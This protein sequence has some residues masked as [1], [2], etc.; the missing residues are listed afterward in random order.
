[1][2]PFFWYHG[3]IFTARGVPGLYADVSRADTGERTRQVGP[4]VAIDGPEDRHT[5]VLF[6]LFGHHHDRTESDTYVFPTFFHQRKADGYAV[7][8]LLPLFWRSRWKDRTTTVVGPFYDRE[9][10]T[11]HDTGLVPLYFWAKN[12]DRTRLIVPPLL[13][14]HHHDFRAGTSTTVVGPFFHGEGPDR[15]RTVLFPL[16]WSGHEGQRSHRM[17]LPVYWH[18][19][20]GADSRSTVLLP[21]YWSTRGTTRLRALLPVAWYTRDDVSKRGSEALLPLFYASHGP[22]RFTLLTLLAGYSHAPDRRRVYVGPIFVGDSVESS[23]RVVFPLWVSHLDRKSETRTRFLLPLLYFS[24]ANPEKSFTTVLALFWRRTDISSSTTLLLPFVLDVHDYRQSRTT[25]V[26]PLFVRHANE[27]TG[28]SLWMAPLLYHHSTG[29][30]RT[31]VLFP[32]IWDFAHEKTRTTVVFPLFAHWTRESYSG[33]YVFPIFYYRK[34]LA[35]G[36]PDGTW[37]VFVPPLFDAASERPGD[38]RWEILGGLFGK[39]RIGRNHYLKVF[40]LTFQTQKASA[41][42]TSW[43][44]QPRRTSR[45]HPTHGLATNTW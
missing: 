37:R 22:D 30:D 38:L 2:G 32:L 8:T 18:F 24:R 35:A 3:K 21:F 9:S 6:P 13:T 33:T 43:Y 4:F 15:G 42:Q 20:D 11:V 12:P 10:S 19:A 5:R 31:N 27:V 36:Q 41:A 28:E 34:G 40:F 45:T 39:E 14:Y 23:T 25:V 17:L 44:G 16:Y 1:V 7:D 29:A 26:L